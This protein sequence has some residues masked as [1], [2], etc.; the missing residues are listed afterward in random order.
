MTPP[1]RSGGPR[2]NE[3][4]A[5]ALT[6]FIGAKT[7]RMKKLHQ[8]RPLLK[9]TSGADARE[10][11]R[12]YEVEATPDFVAAEH[13]IHERE[14]KDVGRREAGAGLARPNPMT[15]DAI[16][17]ADAGKVTPVNVDDL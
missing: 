5:E 4:S 16:R 12:A 9:P 11:M 7:E 13:E 14:M 17:D 15:V 1:K 6:P 8:L 10:R 2:D 3:L